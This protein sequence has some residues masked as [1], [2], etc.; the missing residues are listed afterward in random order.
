M[1]QNIFH[2]PRPPKVKRKRERE[3]ERARKKIVSKFQPCRVLDIF[4]KCSFKFKISFEI[5]PSPL[6]LSI[7]DQYSTSYPSDLKVWEAIPVVDVNSQLA[8]YL[9]PPNSDVSNLAN[10]EY[11]I[12]SY[13]PLENEAPTLEQE[14]TYTKPDLGSFLSA[15]QGLKSQFPLRHKLKK[16]LNHGLFGKHKGFPLLEAGAYV[17]DLTHH[18]ANSLYQKH[19]PKF[20]PIPLSI[21]NLEVSDP[22]GLEVSVFKS[23][24]VP[25]AGV[26]LLGAAA[27]AMVVTNPFIWSLPF[28]LLLGPTSFGHLSHFFGRRRRRDVHSEPNN[29]TISND[30]IV[31]KIE[32]VKILD[33]FLRKVRKFIQGY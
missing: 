5:N 30:V 28:T 24:L 32:E 15:L 19:I 29:R 3:N 7:P 2:S 8:P 23:I 4:S 33:D 20:S 13:R 16:H 17:G 11:M 22:Y 27:T 14:P 26:A 18:F 9:Q 10:Y 21:A 25:L 31:K 1:K 12:D 6:F